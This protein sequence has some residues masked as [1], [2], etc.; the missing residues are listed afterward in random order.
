MVQ[1]LLNENFINHHG[2]LESNGS[3]S[4]T[5]EKDNVNLNIISRGKISGVQVELS[6]IADTK[7]LENLSLPVGWIINFSNKSINPKVILFDATGTNST[8]NIQLR[9]GNLKLSLKLRNPI[10]LL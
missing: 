5:D 9:L 8:N 7:F 6:N 3:V 10:Q 2:Q 4:I 1:L